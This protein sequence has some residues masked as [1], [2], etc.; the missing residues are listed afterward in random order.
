MS[1]YIFS[2]VDN[3][4]AAAVQQRNP[5]GEIR[6]TS[7]LFSEARISL[8]PDWPQSQ[9]CQPQSRGNPLLRR[10]TGI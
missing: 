7:V 1:F 3:L 4:D 5:I 9:L 6:T 8:L 2:A 10:F